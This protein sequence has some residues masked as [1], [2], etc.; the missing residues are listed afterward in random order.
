MLKLEQNSRDSRFCKRFDFVLWS[1]LTLLP[2]ISWLFYLFQS[3]QGLETVAFVDWI[4]TYFAFSAAKN[5]IFSA[6]DGIF[7]FSTGLF[8]VLQPAWILF[9]TWFCTVEI[10]HICVDVLLFIIRLAHKWIGGFVL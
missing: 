9:F 5:P 6:L 3:G 1:F 10:V 7:N 8:P 4:T 2:V